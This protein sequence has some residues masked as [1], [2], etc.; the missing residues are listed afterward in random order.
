LTKNSHAEAGPGTAVVCDPSWHCGGLRPVLALRW[1]S[2]SADVGESRRSVGRRMSSVSVRRAPHILWAAQCTRPRARRAALHSVAPIVA[3]DTLLRPGDVAPV[4]RRAR[5]A[6]AA[7][8]RSR[9]RVGLVPPRHRYRAALVRQPVLLRKQ[10]TRSRR[11]A[12]RCAACAVLQRIARRCVVLQRVARRC[13]GLQ[14]IARYSRGVA[15]NRNIFARCCNAVHRSVGAQRQ[16]ARTDG[17]AP[18]A[19]YSPIPAPTL[20]TPACSGLYGL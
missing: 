10:P 1:A 15:T 9:G 3:R 13:A 7:C 14:R 17:R 18:H 2:P 12:R 4:T 20:G 6:H 19:E 5:G 11:V 8:A 16:C